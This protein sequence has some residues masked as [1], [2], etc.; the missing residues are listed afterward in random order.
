MN[1]AYADSLTVDQIVELIEGSDYLGVDTETNGEDI[2]DGRGFGI[3]MSVGGDYCGV[4][5][6]SYLPVRH[7]HGD[8]ISV[9]DFQR[10]K[11][12]IENFKGWIFFHNA[13]FDLLSLKTMGIN[14]R[15]RFYCT[16]LMAN[17]INENLPFA[18]SLNEVCK[19]YLDGEESKKQGPDF[20][21]AKKIYGWDMPVEHMNEYAAY[22]A[23]LAYRVG[24]A[25][26]PFFKREVSAEYWEHKQKFHHVI[27]DME[28]LGVTVDIPRAKRMITI[29]ESCMQDIVEELGVN[30]GSRKD[31]EYLLIE[32]LGLPVV[33]KSPKTQAPS[34]DKFAMEEYEEILESKNNPLAEKIL[35]YR[36]WQTAVGLNY[37]AYI[38]YVSHDGRVRP[39]YKLDGT[40]TGR[41]SCS[42]PNLQQI[43]KESVKEWNGDLKEC[44]VPEKGYRLYEVDYSQLELRLAAA[45]AKETSLLTVFAEGRDIFTEMSKTLG[46]TRQDTK[47]FVYSIQYG[48]GVNRLMNVFGWTSDQAR[49]RREAFFNTYRGMRV[50]SNIAKNKCLTEGKVKIWTG[51]Y[52]HFRFRTEESHKAFNSVMQGG[53][54]DIVEYA[55][56][57]LHEEVVNDDCRMLL[58]VHDSVWFEIKEGEEEKYFPRIEEIMVEKSKDFG[59][60]F[61]VEINPVGGK[62]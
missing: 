41:L 6:L 56:V 30:P 53:G 51:R 23:S 2:R 57:K 32:K 27:N 37:K 25:M 8:N 58:Q 16:M 46:M 40:K 43:P 60:Q 10:I 29:G 34:F 13:K 45:Y 5:M 39:H 50:I 21:L 48:G 4:H 35:A 54:A 19:M 20:E 36:G 59:V 28:S 42:K 26:L 14:Y 1:T 22:D 7:T 3:G 55:M 38:E 11:N 18:R 33:K 31:L 9:Q 47:T 12:A 61:A 49:E 62:S 24:I 44:F 15:G 17:L 52:R